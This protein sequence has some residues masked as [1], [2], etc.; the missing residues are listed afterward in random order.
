ML[1]ETGGSRKYKPNL[2]NSHRH[3]LQIPQNLPRAKEEDAG[4]ADDPRRIFRKV[5]S[6]LD[7]WFL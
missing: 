5:V 3:F 4:G 7:Q 6:A 1:R 2:H